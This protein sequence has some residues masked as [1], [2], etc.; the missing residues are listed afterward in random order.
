MRVGIYDGVP[1]NRE[2][3]MVPAVNWSD[4]RLVY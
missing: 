1:Y 4:G 3:H 2:R